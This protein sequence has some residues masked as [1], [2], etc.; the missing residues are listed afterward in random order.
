MIKID[1]NVLS[2][3]LEKNRQSAF[4]FQKRRHDDWLENYQLYRDKVVINRLTQR[5]SVNVSLMKETVK[6]LLARI[7]DAPDV[8]FDDQANDKEKEI[9][10]NA[11]WKDYLWRDKLEIKDIVDKKQ[12]LIYGRTWKILNIVQGLPICEI[13]DPYDVLVDRM[14]DPSDLDNTAQ[15]IILQ[16]IFKPLKNLERNPLY[17]KEALKRLRI[18]FANKNGLVK[19]AENQESLAAKNERLESM[20]VP[21][22][23]NPELGETYVEINYHFIKLY[24]KDKKKETLCV[25]CKAEDEILMVKPI[26]ELLGIDFFPTNTWSDDIE[27]TDIYPDAVADIV[28]TP[29][30]VVNAWLSQL[31]ENR[32]MRNYGM[33]YYDSTIEGFIPP[34]FEPKPWGWYPVPGKPKEV[35]EKVDIPELSESLDEMTFM[36]GMV[37][38]A[39]AATA[40][41][42]GVKEGRQITLGEV[43]LMTDKATERITS[44]AKFY[45][46]AWREFGEKWIKL[47]EANAGKLKELELYKKSFKGNFF[48]KKVKPTMFK[49]TAGWNIRVISSAEQEQESL[50]TVEKLAAIKIDFQGNEAFGKIYKKKLLDLAKLSPDEISEVLDEEKQKQEVINT[51]ALPMTPGQL[52]PMPTPAMANV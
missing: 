16:H 13:F 14:A 34:M 32:T 48:S 44:M 50:N 28:R 27:R 43:K 10:A 1:L 38:R 49:S 5:Q 24:D 47:V 51:G 17:N 41:E 19:M 15:F 22:I 23:E 30:K 52:V 11:Y 45:R 26:K 20:G 7:D 12:V 3:T 18:F 35:F 2:T 33:N 4:D 21:D 6:T 36:I 31:V 9:L 39:T 29:N 8:F 42:K 25:V 37:E 46:I 40:T